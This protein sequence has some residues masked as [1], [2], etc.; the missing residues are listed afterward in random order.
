MAKFVQKFGG[1]SVGN[2]ERLENVV[3][4]I[5]DSAQN[6][7]IAVV[8]SA[9]SSYTKAEGTTSRLLAAG[10]LAL[11][12]GTYFKVI[13]LIEELHVDTLQQSI[14][15]ANLREEIKEKIH[16]ELR[17]LKSF[18]DA[19][20]VIRE[21]SP[22]SQDVIVGTGERLS[23]LLVSG[24]LRDRGCDAVYVNMSDV[25][26][27]TTPATESSFYPK[28]TAGML[29]KLPKSPQTI[30]VVTGYFG[31]VPG[32]IIS[33]IGR[34][35]TDLTA[36]L[37]AAAIQADELQIWKEVDGIFSADPRK[38]PKAKVLEEISPAEA[39][40]L[41]YFGSEVLHPFTMERA[42]NAAVPIRIKNTF[43]PEKLGTV[44][45]PV[46][47]NPI[48]VDSINFKQVAA[49]VTAKNQISVLNINSNRMLHSAGFLAKVFET[50]KQHGIVID[51]I[52]TSE[53]N[54]SC[55]VDKSDKL[56]QLIEE[57]KQFSS[58]TCVS[59]RSILSLVGD[60]MKH[61]P[62]VAGQLFT[63]LAKNKINIEMIT[64]GASEINI[65]CV[66]DQKDALKALQTVHKVFLE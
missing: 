4:I 11:A 40:E 7:Q 13:D 33:A 15:A 45:Y 63:H 56:P 50:F 8:V 20:A 29:N 16:S 28:L 24:I 58:V 3:R 60:G 49:A 48:N 44:I 5:Q 54:I 52:C 27:D 12:G 25:I 47:K 59:D 26:T 23:A 1:T 14:K 19:I 10:E 32:G 22:R 62:G 42:I 51:L 6:N 31:F 36:A 18:L 37:I 46:R 17:S 39:A 43:A 35:Y 61:V 41:T 55:A 9:M 57:L 34:G 65:S 2:A 64:Q 21:I 38:V 30:A 53:V 66:I